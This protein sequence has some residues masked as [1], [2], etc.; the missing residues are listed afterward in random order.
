MKT[1]I[2]LRLPKKSK[3]TK[4]LAKRAPTNK[5]D[6]EYQCGSVHVDV[7]ASEYELHV[8]DGN[9]GAVILLEHEEVPA[10]NP[11]KLV[12]GQIPAP[13]IK[14]LQGDATLEDADKDQIVVWSDSD[15]AEVTY[16]RD[17]QLVATP[18]DVRELIPDVDS[19]GHYT[20]IAVDAKRLKE[21]AEAMG[22]DKLILTATRGPE[23]LSSDADP[24]LHVRP[25][26]GGHVGFIR[27]AE[28]PRAKTV[29]E[30]GEE[31]T[32]PLIED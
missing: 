12:S 5:V 21:L 23:A 10:E 27:Q 13:A 32:E 16:Q 30:A 2:R 20:E 14:L 4:V 6:S 7:K 31:A 17:P 9:R 8:T 26:N 28:R 29:E 11:S 3:P 19:P 25:I 22:S 1:A 18:Q 15:D 24:V